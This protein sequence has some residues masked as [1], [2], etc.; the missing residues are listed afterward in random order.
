M[1]SM[2]KMLVLVFSLVFGIVLIFLTF[3]PSTT[4]PTEPYNVTV[5]KLLS[6]PERYVGKVVIVSGY[7]KALSIDRFSEKKSE[8]KYLL[9]DDGDFIE[10]IFS[11]PPEFGAIGTRV[12]VKGEVIVKDSTPFLKVEEYW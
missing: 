7:L 3:Q 8:I 9:E 2:M 4:S 12:T 1:K 10:L 11:K 6:D 5:G